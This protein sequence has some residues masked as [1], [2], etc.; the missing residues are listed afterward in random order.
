MKYKGDTLKNIMLQIGVVIERGYQ[1][2][3]LPESFS[4]YDFRELEIIFWCYNSGKNYY[5]PNSRIA[6]YVIDKGIN[7]REVC[8][9]YR[10]DLGG[11]EDK[12]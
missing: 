9:I 12:C 6:E 5:T 3:E 8:M 10:I 2:G 11:G 7:V 1:T 4:L